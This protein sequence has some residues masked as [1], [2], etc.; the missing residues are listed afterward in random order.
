MGIY[1]DLKIAYYRKKM[2]SQVPD[3]VGVVVPKLAICVTEL[4]AYLFLSFSFFSVLR[5][6]IPIFLELL[7]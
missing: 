3:L 2:S 6:K 1:V 5:M 4:V 7:E